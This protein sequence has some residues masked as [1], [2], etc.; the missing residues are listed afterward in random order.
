MPNLTRNPASS[1]DNEEKEV[2]TRTL[3]QVDKETCDSCGKGVVA[4]YRVNKGES[5]MFFCAHHIRKF[6]GNLREQGFTITPPDISF[7]AGVER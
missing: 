7:T 3:P 6:A 1:K 4:T 5:D 2:F